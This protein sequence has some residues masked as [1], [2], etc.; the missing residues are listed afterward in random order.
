NNPALFA[1][2]EEFSYR[3]WQ[4]HPTAL[5]DWRQRGIKTRFYRVGENHRY[6]AFDPQAPFER[7]IYI[8]A[9]AL[10]MGPL[11]PVFAALEQADVA[12]YDFQ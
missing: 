3:V 9:D 1:E 8:D 7:F 5:A 4:T 6:V 12:I 11:T 2:W 10:V